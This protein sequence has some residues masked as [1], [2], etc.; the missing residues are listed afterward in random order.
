MTSF[1]S[2]ARIGLGLAVW[3]ALAGMAWAEQGEA[4]P[5]TVGTGA[6][7]KDVCFGRVYD[8]A[9]MKAHPRQ[10][11]V[12]FFLLQGHD[13][14]SRPSEDPSY[15][16]GSGYNAYM[17]TT[18]R[19][20]TKPEWTGGWCGSLEDGGAAGEISCGMECDRHMADL[21]RD[22]KG[23]LLVSGIDPDIYL[24]PDAEETLGPAGYEKQRLGG[25]DDGFLLD[26]M[27]AAACQAEFARVDPV[28]PA[29][30]PPLRQRLKP[31]QQ[32]CYGRDY[33]AGH[34]GS[35]PDQATETIR[36]K[37]GSAELASFAANGNAEAWPNGAD[38]A[39]S[40]TTRGRSGKATQAYSCQGEGDQWRCAASAAA[41]DAAC[42]IAGKEIFLRRGANGTMMLANPNSSLP[43]L[44]LCSTAAQGDTKSDDRVFRLDPMPQ[45]ACG[46]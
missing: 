37:R 36:V 43:I 15:A 33:N 42:D 6:D 2:I 23:R 13:P 28:D 20:A 17:T 10:K 16:A 9:H 7:G 45:A 32:F 29:L 18:V 30:G 41:G 38:I 24:D 40:V 25:D 3:S 12:R 22:A 46:P 39:V 8:A 34:L 26:P 11:V 5:A 35:H 4:Q 19:G 14:V 31:D 1:A 27:P 44:D 21:K